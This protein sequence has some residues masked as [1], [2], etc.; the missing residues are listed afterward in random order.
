MSS[1]KLKALEY[2][3]YMLSAAFLDATLGTLYYLKYMSKNPGNDL[4]WFVV[5]VGLIGSVSYY[6]MAKYVA[7][8]NVSNNDNP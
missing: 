2:F 7:S 1:K 6:I 8:R 3:S 5:P 4:M